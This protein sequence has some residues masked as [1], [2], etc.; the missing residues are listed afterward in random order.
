MRVGGEKCVVWK[1]K[2]T[3]V[4]DGLRITQELAEVMENV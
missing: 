2:N 3:P 4:V 1:Q